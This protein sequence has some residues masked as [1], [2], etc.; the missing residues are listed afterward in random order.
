MLHA[1]DASVTVTQIEPYVCS[2]G[3]DCT[4]GGDI[5]MIGCLAVCRL[6]GQLDMHAQLFKA[7]T[8]PSLL[9]TAY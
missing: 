1:H 9:P 4:L 5:L 2:A 3:L 6:W 8:R 7:R